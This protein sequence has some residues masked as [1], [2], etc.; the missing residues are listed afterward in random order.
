MPQ[1][2]MITDRVVKAS[3][4]SSAVGKMTFWTSDN[5]SLDDLANWTA[6]TAASFKSKLVATADAFPDASQVENSD[7]KHVCFFVHGYNVG[8]EDGA[9]RYKKICDTLFSGKNS[10]GVCI[11]MDWPSLGSLLGYLPDRDH[12]RECA[13]DVADIFDTVNQ[14]LLLK[15]RQTDV[16]PSKACKAKVSIIAHSMGNYVT[17]KALSS[18]WKRNNQP[19]SVSLIN[20]LVMVAADVDND[21]F[22]AKGEDA[23]D[24]EAVANLSYRIS[25]LYS[26]RDDVLGTSAGLKHFGTRRL[27]RSGLATEPPLEADGTTMPECSVTL[28]R[29]EPTEFALELA[30]SW[31]SCPILT[32]GADASQTECHAQ[33]YRGPT[34]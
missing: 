26:G 3:K 27:G 14:W 5:S 18:V 12:A 1:Y 30:F 6:E 34:A 25:S 33:D 8:F 20:Q 22:D 16:D 24:G 11:S 10:L 23:T 31:L 7:Q 9:Q 29:N 32:G 13:A 4:P 2:W 28:D 15:Q 21:L 17:Q 19:L